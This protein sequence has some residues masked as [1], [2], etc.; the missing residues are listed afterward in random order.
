MDDKIALIENKILELN[1][2]INQF[3]FENEKL[4]KKEKRKIYN[5]KYY[6]NKIKSSKV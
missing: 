1:N 6:Q 3:K 2:L 5:K 4:D